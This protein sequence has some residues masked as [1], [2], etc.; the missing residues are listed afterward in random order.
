MRRCRA[1]YREIGT[2]TPDREVGCRE[3]GCR[4][5]ET[6]ERKGAAIM[7]SISEQTLTVDDHALAEPSRPRYAV[8]KDG[9]A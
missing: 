3:V 2:Q 7:T 1:G 5:V 6:G 9:H 4:E 8:P